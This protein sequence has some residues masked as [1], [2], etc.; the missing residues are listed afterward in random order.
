MRAKPTQRIAIFIVLTL[1]FCAV[2]SA[3]TAS[4]PNAIEPVAHTEFNPKGINDAYFTLKPV[5]FLFQVLPDYTW[6][7]EVNLS[8]VY[9]KTALVQTVQTNNAITDEFTDLTSPKKSGGV[10]LILI[11]PLAL[12][13]MWLSGVFQ[14][15]GN[16]SNIFLIV[17]VLLVLGLIIAA[18]VEGFTKPSSFVTFD[19]A[20]DSA[21]VIQIDEKEISLPALTYMKV[22]LDTG[23]HALKI[24]CGAATNLFY[25]ETIRVKKTKLAIYNI[26]GLNTYT[27]MRGQYTGGY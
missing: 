20:A 16:C 17:F 6:T 8:G 25:T 21:C 5:D 10:L 27:V 3:C 2:L 11:F 14:L 22:N 18:L 12:G 13:S 26:A 15:K 23:D 4:L 1:A 7:S 24:N 9:N 19:N